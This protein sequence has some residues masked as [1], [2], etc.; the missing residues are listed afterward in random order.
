M[1]VHVGA[2]FVVV[3]A[4]VIVAVVVVAMHIGANANFSTEAIAPVV[5]IDCYGSCCCFYGYYG[6]CSSCYEARVTR[7][8]I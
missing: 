2:S 8:P 1:A 3:V 6:R 7:A 4:V 5:D